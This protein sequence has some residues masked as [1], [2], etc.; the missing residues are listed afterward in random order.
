MEILIHQHDT[1]TISPYTQSG[2]TLMQMSEPI[3]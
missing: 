3:A 1:H 2:Y